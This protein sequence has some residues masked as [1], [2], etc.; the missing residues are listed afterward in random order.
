M[1]INNVHFT[2]YTSPTQ[3]TL[4]TTM[5]LVVIHGTSQIDYYIIH[6]RLKDVDINNNIVPSIKIKTR[7]SNTITFIVQTED[8]FCMIHV[9]ALCLD[10][11]NYYGPY[12][13]SVSMKSL[14]Y[15]HLS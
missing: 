4:Q 15:Y 12:F 6:V 2:V 7:T 3:F 14:Y 13:I 11:S 5:P 8:S 10:L 9:T 1:E